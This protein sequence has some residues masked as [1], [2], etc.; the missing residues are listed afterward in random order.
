MME[1]I[2][3][4][5]I[6]T[7]LFY[8]HIYI[9]I[10]LFERGIFE[11]WLKIIPSEWKLDKANNIL[12][13]FP[14]TFQKYQFC[15]IKNLENLSSP[16]SPSSL[17]SSPYNQDSLRPELPFVCNGESRKDQIAGVRR[18]RGRRWWWWLEER[19]GN[20]GRRP[21][22]NERRT[23]RDREGPT[24]ASSP[25]TSHLIIPFFSPICTILL[26]S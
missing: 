8:T 14:H 18:R 22:R 16:S 4:I 10:Y 6:Y 2:V 1:N 7:I 20:K 13:F 5:K 17:C 3:I 19:R 24:S 9:Y 23:K 15:E 21:G 11:I 25:S 12:S 26:L